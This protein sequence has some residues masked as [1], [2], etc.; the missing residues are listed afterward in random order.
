VCAMGALASGEQHPLA[1]IVAEH[2]AAL[3]SLIRAMAN[4]DDP[5]PAD[6]GARAEEFGQRPKAP[7]RYQPIAI[8]IHE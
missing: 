4:S 7:G 3:L 2:G 1:A 8:T 5:G 6:E